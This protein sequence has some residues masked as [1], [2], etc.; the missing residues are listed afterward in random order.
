[1]GIH[2]FYSTS[3]VISLHTLVTIKT[4][5][6]HFNVYDLDQHMSQILLHY[7]HCGSVSILIEAN[8]IILWCCIQP[9]RICLPKRLGVK[10]TILCVSR[11]KRHHCACCITHC[12]HYFSWFTQCFEMGYCWFHCGSMEIMVLY[13]PQ[14]ST[15]LTL[16]N[17]TSLYI[18]NNSL[19]TQFSYMEFYYCKQNSY[20]L[21]CTN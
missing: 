10:N 21:V 2:S 5:T 19:Y 3:N 1:M 8:N 6:V 14:N 16:T 15:T 4:H 9:T 17:Y 12:T 7:K 13:I 11:E 18:L 20:V